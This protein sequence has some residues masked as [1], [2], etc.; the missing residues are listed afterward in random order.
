MTRQNVGHHFLF[1]KLSKG[2]NIAPDKIPKIPILTPN[3]IIAMGKDKREQYLAN[4]LK[5]IS[6]ISWEA[7]VFR[8]QFEEIG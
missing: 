4:A 8:I 3:S 5:Y 7:S 2:C 1:D 6:R